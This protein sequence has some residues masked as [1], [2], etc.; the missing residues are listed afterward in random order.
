MEVCGG[1]GT[2][3]LM[4]ICV[5]WVGWGGGGERKGP[6]MG[7]MHTWGCYYAQFSGEWCVVVHVCG[8][9]VVY[10]AGSPDVCVRVCVSVSVCVCERERER[11]CVC[12]RVC[13]CVHSDVCLCTCMHRHVGGLCPPHTHTCAAGAP[14]LWFQG[15][16]PCGAPAPQC[17]GA[18]VAGGQVRG[19]ASSGRCVCV[20]G[21][22]G[23][24]CAGRHS[25]PKQTCTAAIHTAWPAYPL[26]TPSLPTWTPLNPSPPTPPPHPHHSH[27]PL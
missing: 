16:A 3:A 18:S 2:G 9:R 14:G 5:C 1:V 24:R 15:V 4:E 13:A 23:Q 19:H 17:L 20:C 7:C 27:G 25:G 12:V 10:M 8:V 6:P 26:H 22:G 21:G 11:V